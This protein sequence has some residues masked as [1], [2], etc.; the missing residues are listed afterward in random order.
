MMSEP[1]DHS[2]KA[3]MAN[4]ILIFVAIVAL[5]FLQIGTSF[6][7]L[8]QNAVFANLLIAGTQACLLAYYFMHLKGADNLTWLIVGAGLFWLAILFTLMMTD[9]ITR[10]LGVY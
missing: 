6:M 1:S 2:E 10:H 3:P 4:Y 7:G 8:G 9:Y 5:V